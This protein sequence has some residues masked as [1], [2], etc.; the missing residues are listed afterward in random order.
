MLHGVEA[1]EGAWESGA[2]LSVSDSTGSVG[3]LLSG[4]GDFTGKPKPAGRVSVVGIMDQEDTSLPFHDAHRVWVKKNADVAAAL[5]ACRELQ[6]RSAGDSVALAGKVVSQV[7]DGYFYV[8]D[9]GRAGGVRVVSDRDVTPGDVVSVMGTVVESDG[10]KVVT[11]RYLAFG[12]SRAMP[13]TIGA[14]LSRGLSPDGLLVRLPGTAGASTGGGSF[15]LIQDSGESVSVS[16]SGGDIP[17]A[18]SRVA[19]TG[20]AVSR[21]GAFEVEAANAGGIRALD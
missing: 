18:G 2:L 1:G 15:E 21:N 14:G 13:L 12:K 5:G 6:G 20:I 17:A 16:L 4:M 19:L 7:F 10:E 3:L 9:E 8:Q 11:A